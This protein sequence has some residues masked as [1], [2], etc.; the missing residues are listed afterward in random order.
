MPLLSQQ[1]HC[2][3]DEVAANRNAD[4]ARLS[5][6]LDR[7]LVIPFDTPQGSPSTNGQLI[8]GICPLPMPLFYSIPF[9]TTSV[10]DSTT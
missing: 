9:S 1:H 7:Q 10:S 8:F 2:V 5:L 6:G 3:A 4:R